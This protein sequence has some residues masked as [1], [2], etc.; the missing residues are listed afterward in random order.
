MGKFAITKSL[1]EGFCAKGLTV[2]EMVD[3]ITKRSGISCTTN[4]VKKACDYHKIN[5]RS[6]PKKSDFTFEEEDVEETDNLEET[7]Q[8]DDNIGVF[9]SA[10]S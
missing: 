9:G 7:K 2:K 4:Y 10:E 3:E 6:K 5:L 8:E 1:L